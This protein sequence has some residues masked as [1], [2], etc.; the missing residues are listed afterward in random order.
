M[1]KLTPRLQCVADLT[2][3]CEGLIDIGTDHAYLP[4]YLIAENRIKRAVASDINENPL[5]NAE[6]TVKQENLEDRI[7][8]RL[9]DGF[10][11]INENDGTEIV[12]AGLGGLMIAEM[13]N[14]TP[15]LQNKKYHLVIQ[16]MTHFE[17]VRF[18]LNQNGF[19]IDREV[20]ASEGKHVYL[21]LSA[22]YIGKVSHKPTYWYYTGD[23]IGRRGLSEVEF[24][25]RIKKSLLHKYEG[26]GDEVTLE[27]LRSIENAEG[28]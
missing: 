14:K 19:E 27:I 16:P 18:T 20:V 6:N 17:D 25:D 2:E 23:L 13:L 24:L 8:L 12:I 7:E 4:A 26:T 22:R 3:N 28:K 10:E 15:W 1:I 5:K 9:S 21:I 11:N